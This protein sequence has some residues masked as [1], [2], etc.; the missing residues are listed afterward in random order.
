ML[1]R[2]G[3]VKLLAVITGVIILNIAVLSPG[4][5][6]VEI[7]GE[8]ALETASGVTLLF[9]SLLIVLY[10]SYSLLFKAPAP[11]SARPLTSPDDYAAMLQQ[12]KNV[13]VLKNDVLLA[14]DQLE[15]MEKKKTT[16]TRV[17]SERFDPLEL[18]YRK[19]S[20]VIAEVEKL[21]Y[22]N[23]RGMLNKLSLFD[24]SEF[25]LF[26][27]THKPPPFSEKLIQKKTALYKDFFTSL[28]GYLGANEEILLK[29]DQLLLEISELDSTNYKEVEE[30]PCMQ[31]LSALINQT[32]L[33]Q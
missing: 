24:T 30:M 33:Y 2:S 17:L 20:S 6:N 16:L 28:K 27:N 1:N 26:A 4:L 10:G 14:L 31:E 8:S 15:R 25:S 18:S 9:I 19:F 12:Y 7:G 5:L 22:L 3:P 23:V 13:K 29:L 11:K 32:K 21:L